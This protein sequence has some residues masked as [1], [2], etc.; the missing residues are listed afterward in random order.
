MRLR[1][2]SAPTTPNDG[3]IWWESNTTTGLKM[4][5]NGVTRTITMT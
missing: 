3:D 2:G 5:V 1:V 4:R